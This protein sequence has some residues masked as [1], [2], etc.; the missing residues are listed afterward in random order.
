MSVDL[1]LFKGDECMCHGTIRIDKKRQSSEFTGDNGLLLLIS[2]EFS[3]PACG[4]SVELWRETEVEGEELEQILESGLAMGVHE[5]S[6]WES[7]SLGPE[8]TLAFFCHP[9]P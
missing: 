8:Y 2:Y 4:L 9:A 6:E 7:V 5:S 1:A 3:L